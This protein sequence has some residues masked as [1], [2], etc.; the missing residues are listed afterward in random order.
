MN[1]PAF[2]SLN[3][4]T[5]SWR[6]FMTMGPCQ[7]RLCHVNS[8]RVHAKV[9]EAAPDHVVLEGGERVDARTVVVATDRTSAQQLHAADDA[10]GARREHAPEDAQQCRLARSVRS[11]NAVNAAR[12]EGQVDAPQSCD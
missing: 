4:C 2:S 6:V 10:P 7:G 8:I 9:A 1:V 3:A 12:L 11:D 5:S